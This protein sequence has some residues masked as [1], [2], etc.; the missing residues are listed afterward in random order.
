M[1]LRLYLDGVLVAQSRLATGETA[2]TVFSVSHDCGSA[3][4]TLTQSDIWDRS[5]QEWVPG[6]AGYSS[7]IKYWDSLNIAVNQGY[8]LV[9]Y[10]V[11]YSGSEGW[12][13][14]IPVDQ[15][16]MVRECGPYA[17]NDAY[18]TNGAEMYNWWRAYDPS[19]PQDGYTF[20]IDIYFH[21]ATHKILRD[22]ATGRII[23]TAYKQFVRDD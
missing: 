15:H 13:I 2:G 3:D 6:S 17:W 10:D 16:E 18:L 12:G 22:A 11:K 5:K 1:R 23:R 9:M 4:I 20:K 8:S 21:S 7:W 14:G 19:A